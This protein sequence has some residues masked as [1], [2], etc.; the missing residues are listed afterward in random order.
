MAVKQ[1]PNKFYKQKK[2]ELNCKL[3]SKNAF[4]HGCIIRRTC[5]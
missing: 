5:M 3:K 1:Q 2:K 4:V